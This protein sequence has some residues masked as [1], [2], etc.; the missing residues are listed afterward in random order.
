[1]RYMTNMRAA[2][3]VAILTIGTAFQAFGSPQD[4][5]IVPARTRIVRLALDLHALRGVTL[6]SYAN[7]DDP[8]RPL[9]HVW[10]PT[11]RAWE[12]IELEQ[13]PVHDRIPEQPQVLYL[14]GNETILPPGIPSVLDHAVRQVSV[15]SLSISEILRQFDPTMG[16]SA[17][18]WRSLASRHNLQIREIRHERRRWHRFGGPQAPE[19][20][21]PQTD[22]PAPASEPA[23]VAEPAPEPEPITME[24]ATDLPP[25]PLPEQP[26]GPAAE[27]QA[28]E[29]VP[30]VEE[31]GA[32][33]TEDTDAAAVE[34]SEPL[35]LE[36]EPAP[37]DDPIPEKQ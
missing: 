19:A 16:F 36:P 2:L 37:Q 11:T 21:A 24:E 18:E 23:P 12:R 35:D 6:V 29:G 34:P 5:L 20:P 32:P 22:T 30:D 15:A 4:V 25:K 27:P 8:Q 14:I 3:V 9:L 33:E 10:A 28:D 17:A 7:T 26:E 31:K 13:L 1:M